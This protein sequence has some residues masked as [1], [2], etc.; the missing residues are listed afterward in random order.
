[1]TEAKRLLPNIF[2]ITGCPHRVTPE[3]LAEAAGKWSETFASLPRPLTAVIVGGA[4]KNKPFTTENARRLGESIR[5]IKEQ[6]GGSILLRLHAAPAPKP[7]TSSKKKL[8][9]FRLTLTG[10]AEKKDNPIMGF[11]A[12]ADN[13]IATGDSVSMPC[14][15]CG[16]GK[17]VLLFTGKG[18]LTP[19]HERF[20]KSLIDGGYAVHIDAPDALSFRPQKTLNPAGIIAE[21]ID[22]L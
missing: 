14:E 5:K 18:W 22:A 2:Y 15:C 20:V 11:W 10:G 17:P 19:K 21:K 4:I 16:S 13:I 8:R 6:T 7:K 1:M 3:A 12:L 9:E